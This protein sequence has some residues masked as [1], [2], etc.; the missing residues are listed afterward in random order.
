MGIIKVEVKIAE[1]VKA[2]KICFVSNT[3]RYAHTQ[4]LFRLNRSMAAKGLVR[5]SI[6]VTDKAIQFVSSFW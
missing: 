1:L 3:N 5:H 4:S 6:E 2:V